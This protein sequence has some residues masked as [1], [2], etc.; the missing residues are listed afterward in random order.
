MGIKLFVLGL[1]LVSIFSFFSEIVKHKVIKNKNDT[2][3]VT[4]TDAM[5]YTMTYDEVLRI[6]Q[7]KTA[8]RYKSRDEMYDA[9]IINRVQDKK[10]GEVKDIISA[11]K[12]VKK[13]NLYMLYN[14]VKYDRDIFLSLRTNELFYDIKNEIAY[15][16][17][18]FKAKYNGDILNGDKFYLDNKTKLLKANKSHFEINMNKQ[19]T[20]K[21]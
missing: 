10:H 18:P 20:K 9:T 3:L 4:F 19:S 5:M 12:M 14:N 13:E 21:N 8:V 7:A 16:S 15:N 17:L 11:E 6:V 1:F 2:P